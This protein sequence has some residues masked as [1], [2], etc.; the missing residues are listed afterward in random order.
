MTSESNKRTWGAR[1]RNKME[2]NERRGIVGIL[3]ERRS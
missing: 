1:Y 3:G 2:I